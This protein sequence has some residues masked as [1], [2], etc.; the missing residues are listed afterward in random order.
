MKIKNKNIVFFLRFANIIR[1]F[2]DFQSF[3]F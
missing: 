2:F 3:Y 1:H